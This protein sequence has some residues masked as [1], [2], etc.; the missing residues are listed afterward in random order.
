MGLYK[1][2]KLLY[3]KESKQLSEEI[4]S[5]EK[6]FENHFYNKGLIPRIYQQVKNST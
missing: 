2:W 5:R 4:A 1:T 6:M 3:F